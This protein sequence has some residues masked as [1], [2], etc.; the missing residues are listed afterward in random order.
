MIEPGED[1][2]VIWEIEV[3][4]GRLTIHRANGITADS[5]GPTLTSREQFEQFVS[6]LRHLASM[7]WPS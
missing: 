2:S 6:E 7:V 3:G 5:E 4:D 1:E